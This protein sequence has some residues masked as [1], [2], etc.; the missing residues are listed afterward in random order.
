MNL[1]P[2]RIAIQIHFDGLGGGKQ[3]EVILA[4][5]LSAPPNDGTLLS[6]LAPKLGDSL[7]IC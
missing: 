3:I 5:H 7:L 2:I 1:V 6:Y 4:G